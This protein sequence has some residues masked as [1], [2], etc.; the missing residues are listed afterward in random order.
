MMN[1]IPAPM[2]ASP[3]TTP[4]TAPAMTAVLDLDPSSVEPLEE[5]PEPLPLPLSPELD[6]PLPV[7]LLLLGELPPF[8]A[9]GPVVL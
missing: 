3:P 7:A 5:P 9:L 8:V 1:Q 2:R 4:T 6:P